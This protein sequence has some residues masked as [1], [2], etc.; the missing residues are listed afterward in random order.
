MGSTGVGIDN[1]V[2]SKGNNCCGYISD[3][4]I[5]AD[6]A[7]KVSSEESVQT[8]VSMLSHF[9]YEARFLDA[10]AFV[11]YSGEGG[12]RCGGQSVG[13]LCRFWEAGGGSSDV[14]ARRGDQVGGTNGVLFF[15]SGVYMVSRYRPSALGG[16]GG[17][18]YHGDE[19]T[20]YSSEGGMSDGMGDG[21]E[22]K[23]YS[24]E[25]YRGDCMG[26]GIGA[27]RGG[28]F[29]G[30]DGSLL[31][32]GRVFGGQVSLVGLGITGLGIDG[33]DRGRQGDADMCSER[34]G[35][36]GG[37]G[38]GVIDAV[39]A[40]NRCAAHRR[41][42]L[43]MLRTYN[44]L[45]RNLDCESWPFHSDGCWSAL[46]SFAEASRVDV[47]RS[48]CGQTFEHALSDGFV[49]W[50]KYLSDDLDEYGFEAWDV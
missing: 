29:A 9:R 24:G 2:D 44:I 11:D 1:T 6:S 25:G 18:G 12:F 35:C 46:L 37:F 17:E 40:V 16:I 28:Q 14:G 26:H 33:A 34:S 13:E 21:E 3:G 50:R 48:S 45:Q 19:G 36:A 49:E 39:T 7:G 43:V 42:L 10:Q 31:R 23:V 4:S 41:T 20:V 32:L 8:D 5:C 47:E 38:N 15:D 27:R 22:G 30:A